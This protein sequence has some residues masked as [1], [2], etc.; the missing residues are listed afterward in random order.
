LSKRLN[1]MIATTDQDCIIDGHYAVD[2]VTPEDVDFVFVLRR[3]PD[4]LKKVME[5]RGYSRKKLQENLEAEILD[6]CL[7]EAVS[8]CGRDKV[9][10]IDAT[11]KAVEDLVREVV[12]T[13]QGKIACKVG[14]V[15]WLGQ[16]EAEKRLSEFLSIS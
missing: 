1:E 9:C 10:E 8:S 6:I 16:L 5:T 15:D 3:N 11:G 13:L 4:E 7:W 14:V 2:T 12:Q